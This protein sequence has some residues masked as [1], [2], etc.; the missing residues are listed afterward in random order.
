MA[1]SRG[2]LEM[3]AKWR[4]KL[5]ARAAAEPARNGMEGSALSRASGS[6]AMLV[7]FVRGK[8]YI[9]CLAG[10]CVVEFGSFFWCVTAACPAG[11][12]K[13]G[14]KKTE[15]YPCLSR[16]G[17]LYYCPPLLETEKSKNSFGNA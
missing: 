2:A 9:R 5:A 13:A 12:L 10:V 4:R 11:V 6:D 17:V 16:I 15:S 8:V 1:W 14:E 7:L 3:V